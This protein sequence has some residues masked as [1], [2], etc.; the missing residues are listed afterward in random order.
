MSVAAQGIC[1]VTDVP[2]I[3]EQLHGA[4]QI[5]ELESDEIAIE[6]SVGSTAH[7][8]R[9][10]QI[11]YN[12]GYPVC[13]TMQ[14]R[15]FEALVASLD[16]FKPDVAV[17]QQSLWPAI[18]QTLARKKVPAVFIARDMRHA[19]EIAEALSGDWPAKPESVVGLS[20]YMCQKLNKVGGAKVECI[21]PIV[22]IDRY[23][24]SDKFPRRY[25]TFI[26]PTWPKG[27]EVFIEI[28]QKLP[29]VPFM[30][31]E[32]WGMRPSIMQLLRRLPNVRYLPKQTD[33]RK[34]YSQTHILLVPSKWEEAFGRVTVEAQ[35]S[36]I[37][38]IASARGGLPEAV[39]DGGILVEDYLNSDIWVNEITSLLECPDRHRDL[40]SKALG[41]TERFRPEPNVK[42]FATIL[43]KAI[44]SY[45]YKHHDSNS[46]G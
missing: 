46:S 14:E 44:Q 32:G 24:V 5:F 4:E 31:V 35:A 20:N 29:D 34:V 12:A 33:M 36:G 42:R 21:N 30:C 41:N 7:I 9:Q 15:F 39:G 17:V 1:T 43:E 2:R 16:L 27:L 3:V 13:L 19:G 40:S 8:P 11:K 23:R 18:L 6:D 22:H 26:N 10:L 28:A 38:V 45:R 25:V 37:P